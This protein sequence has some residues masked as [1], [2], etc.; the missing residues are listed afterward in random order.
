VKQQL[1]PL[2][3][4]LILAGLV[5]MPAFAATSNAQD[6]KKLQQQVNQLAREV[7]T[8]KAQKSNGNRNTTP[9]SARQNSAQT[10]AHVSNNLTG[11]NNLPQSGISYLPVDLDVP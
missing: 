11:P 6:M 7:N 4:G 9:V 5:S 1:K 8:L 10:I 2:A 3:I